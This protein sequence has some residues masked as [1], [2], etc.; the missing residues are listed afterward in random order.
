[1]VPYTQK[2]GGKLPDD[3]LSLAGGLQYAARLAQMKNTDGKNHDVNNYWHHFGSFNWDDD[4]RW[5]HR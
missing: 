1:M 2:V 5:W 4:T 3:Y